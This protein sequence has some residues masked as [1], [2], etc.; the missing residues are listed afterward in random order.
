MPEDRLTI[1]HVPTVPLGSRTAL[2]RP[3]ELRYLWVLL[4]VAALVVIDQ[5]IIQPSLVDL[6]VYA[7]AINLAGRQRMLSQKISKE[8]LV[9]AQA[10]RSAATDS[11]PQRRG[12]LLSCVRQWRTAHHTLMNGDAAAS[13]EPLASP[14][15]RS[16]MLEVS[17]PLNAVAT[18]AVA[19]ADPSTSE[20]ER[21]RQLAVILAGETRYLAAM[22]QIVALLADDARKQIN[23]LHACGLAAMLAILGLM[24]GVYFIVLRPATSVIHEQI[25]ALDAARDELE[26]RVAVR[27]HALSVANA[28]LAL[29]IA[30]RHEAESR[31]RELAAQLAHASRVTALGQLATGLAHEI[32]QPLASIASYADTADLLLENAAPQ[33]AEARHAIVQIRA[34]ALRGGKIVRRMR[35]FVKRGEIQL[36]PV[37]INEL[38]RDV[39]ELCR[40]QLDQAGAKLSV[41][42]QSGPIVAEADPLE[43][44]QVLVNLVQNAAQAVQES[45]R[46][47]RTIVIR[48]RRVEAEVWLEIAD[49]GPGFVGRSAEECFAAFY[50]TKSDGLGLGLAV[51]RTLLARYQGRIWAED[52][53]E[54]GATI[55]FSLPMQS[56]HD[57]KPSDAGHCLCG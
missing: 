23:F 29:E 31:T 1:E 39:C 13:I 43:I 4:S 12:E 5:A 17:T 11:L 20:D 2:V 51:C 18:A 48:T 32:N 7:P 10:S 49:S 30:E 34:A 28:A 46:E 6:N 8:A 19:I 25:A 56:T 16:K 47:R 53:A 26:A 55:V 42:L 36:Q 24:A 37:E 14:L 44:Q 15:V 35:N 40:P 33:L 38:V 41:E 9:L 52:A 21:G 57:V 27:T 22:E 54:A 50:S 3:L 45:P